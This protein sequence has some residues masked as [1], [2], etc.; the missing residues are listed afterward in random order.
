MDAERIRFEDADAFALLLAACR[1]CCEVIDGGNKTC[2]PKVQ[3]EA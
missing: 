3:I 2:P 1:A